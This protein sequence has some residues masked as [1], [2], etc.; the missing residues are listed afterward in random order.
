MGDPQETD[1]G[2]AAPDGPPV[3][4]R[5]DRAD[6]ALFAH[7]LPVE[8]LVRGFVVER[9]GV[10]RAWVERLDFSTLERVP[11]EHIAP[12]LSSRINDTVWRVRLRDGETS[13][14]DG[15]LHVLVMVEFQSELDWFMAL[16]IR[17]Y[18]DLLYA[19]L[20]KDRRPRR[21][22]R[23]PALLPVV[24]YTGAQRW[25]AASSVE[26]LVA[27]QIVPGARPVVAPVFSGA[28]Y[29]VVDTGTYAGQDLPADNIVSLMIGAELRPD[30]ATALDIVAAA[31]R[32]DEELGRTFLAWLR[33]AMSGTGVNLEFLED[34]MAME[35]LEQ[36]G[37]LGGLLEERFRA[38][39]AAQIE[40]A[41]A[42]G[43]EVARAQIEAARAEGREAARAEERGLLCR[44]AA[45]KFGAATA[46]RLAIVLEGVDD[47]DR[48]AVV[49]EHIID[50][51]DGA[52]LLA[53]LESQA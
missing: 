24:L 8:H 48:L 32:L 11:T 36:T 28:S 27:P 19:S 20:W 21:T 9:L 35:R 33:V 29:I 47:G 2:S 12:D 52:A 43:R 7:A 39:N 14:A 44:L 23:L 17:T 3:Q 45:R 6:K 10:D 34:Q 18:A 37:E 13:E 40:A 53:S 38:A 16:R 49:G 31:R 1:P 46:E 50:C 26:A 51:A 30:A 15:W 25:S 22:D 4:R 41:R 5:R 42:E